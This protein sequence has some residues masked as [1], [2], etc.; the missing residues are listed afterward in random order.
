MSQHRIHL[1]VLDIADPCNEKWG[2]MSGDE[3]KRFCGL[4]RQN[5]YNL[6]SMNRADAEAFVAEAEGSVCVRFY[7]RKDGTVVTKDCAPDRLAAARRVA[8]RSLVF[9]G[10]A[11][12]GVLTIVGSLG[13]ASALS[14][15]D[16]VV[17]AIAKAVTGEPEP[18]PMM[19][20]MPAHWDP[21]PEVP[22]SESESPD[23]LTPAPIEEG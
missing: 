9:A 12:A 18:Q 11:M 6:S 8:K 1:D 19:G 15:G 2:A 21:P 7:R 14:A 5:V 3:V 13:F 10:A 22:D 23:E 4:C 17:D 20:A 16:S